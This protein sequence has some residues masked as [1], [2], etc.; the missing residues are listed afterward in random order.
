MNS[1]TDLIHAIEKADRIAI[2][3]HVRPDGDA[4]GSAFGLSRILT[5][6][7]KAVTVCGFDKIPGKYAFLAQASDHIQNG[8]NIDPQAFDLLILLDTGSLDRVPQCFH[9]WISKVRSINIDHHP[10]NTFF[11]DLNYVNAS[12]SSV[13]E[14]ILDLAAA[15]G[16][17]VTRSAAEALWVALVTDTGRFS[18]S[19]TKPSTLR[20]AALLVECGICPDDINR[21]VYE[22]LTE[23]QIR[24]QGRAI[25][26]LEL[27]H[28]G[29]LALVSLSKNDF[30]TL[31]CTGEDADEIVDIPRRIEGVAVAVFL[32][33][34]E[35]E[36][37][38]FTKAGFRTIVPY[39]A[40]AFC[41]RLGGGG[42]ARAA[43]C[44]LKMPLGAARTQ[45]LAQ[46]SD[47]WFAG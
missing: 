24:L 21:R 2:T 47:G 43:G 40:G 12:A 5:A 37:E 33:E 31:G 3:A 1:I 7:G 4:V 6:A 41:D 35:E 22:V 27:F 11:A 13:G 20:A 9:S 8:S 36:K 14:V 23:R 44:T 42:H 19:N 34:Y 38:L 28:E 45:I 15:A 39:D 18:Y 25:Q 29:R 32:S 30:D 46:V 16:Y 17:P 10:T 26:S